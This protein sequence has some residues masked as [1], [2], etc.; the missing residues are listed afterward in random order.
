MITVMK[1]E[2]MPNE[3]PF[4]CRIY[5]VNGYAAFWTR[6]MWIVFCWTN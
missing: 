4:L 3:A 5:K 1:K 2:R 6:S